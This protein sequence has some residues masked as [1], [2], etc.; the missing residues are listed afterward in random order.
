MAS[1]DFTTDTPFDLAEEWRSVPPEV[2]PSGAYEV[3]SHGRVRRIKPAGTGRPLRNGPFLTPWVHKKGYLLLDLR[4]RTVR[5]HTL[6]ALVFLG[7][8][9]AGH[10]VNHVDGNKTHN[11]ITNLE[12]LSH[13]D[14]MKH[15][16]MTGLM[17]R[18][19]ARHNAKLT[20]DD[21]RAIRIAKGIVLQAVLAERYHVSDSYISCIQSRRKWSWLP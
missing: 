14:N 12:Y 5:V 20:A 16:G 9:P 21:V 4:G 1:P 8:I 18:G 2:E 17:E 11:V 19:T 3:S 15:A 10:E 7:P 6:V 13:D